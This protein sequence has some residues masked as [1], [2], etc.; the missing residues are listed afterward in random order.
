MPKHVLYPRL[1]APSLSEALADSPVALIHGPRQCGKA[2]L[3]RMINA[4]RGYTYTSFDDV[5]VRAAA[6]ADP[7]GFAWDLPRCTF[8]LRPAAEASAAPIA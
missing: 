5:V 2:T 3:A 8:C 4:S 7:I 6:E 1:A